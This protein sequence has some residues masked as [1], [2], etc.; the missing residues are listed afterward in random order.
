MANPLT[1]MLPL[2]ADA[3]AS[4]LLEAIH[5]G[6]DTLNRALSLVDTLHFARLLLLDRAA[7]DLRPG[8]TLSGN[9][10]LAMLAEY[11]GELED[12]IR[13]LARE[14]GPQLD[15]LL[16]FVDGGSRLVPAIACISELADFVSQHDVSRGPAGLAHFEAYRATAREI[17]AALP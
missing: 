14:L 6:Q 10:V 4:A 17:A 13:S 2:R 16:A 15:S 12:C 9:H 11:D 3:E 7:P 1:L 5:A 8:P